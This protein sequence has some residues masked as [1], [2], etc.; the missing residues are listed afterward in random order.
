MSTT[1]SQG[2]VAGEFTMRN[3]GPA[4]VGEAP[5]EAVA[6]EGE[7]GERRGVGVVGTQGLVVGEARAGDG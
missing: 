6:G 7:E 5:P 3:A 1:A 4:E 2:E